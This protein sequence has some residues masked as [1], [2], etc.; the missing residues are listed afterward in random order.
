MHVV[1]VLDDGTHQSAFALAVQVA[2]FDDPLEMAVW[3]T[4]VNLSSSS[5]LSSTQTQQVAR[6]THGFTIRNLR[7]L[8]GRT[9]DCAI[10]SRISLRHLDPSILVRNGA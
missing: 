10:R 1:N 9:H 2:S 7:V 6:A 4:S 5:Q 8:S 3:R